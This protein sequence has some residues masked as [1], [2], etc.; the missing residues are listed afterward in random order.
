MDILQTPATVVAV[1][2]APSLTAKATLTACTARAI[3]PAQAPCTV[4][5]SSAAIAAGSDLP[6]AA[7]AVHLRTEMVFSLR[8]QRTRQ[9]TRGGYG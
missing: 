8:I 9:R 7:D 6:A 1:T 2:S 5:T 4:V 3:V